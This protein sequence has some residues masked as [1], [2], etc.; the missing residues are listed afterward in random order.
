M[1]KLLAAYL[2]GAISM[3]IAAYGWAWIGRERT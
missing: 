1:T 3:Y 2:L